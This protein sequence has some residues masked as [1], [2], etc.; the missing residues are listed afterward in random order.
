MHSYSKR[1]SLHQIE[2]NRKG[3]CH[4]SSASSIIPALAALHHLLSNFRD[5]DLLGGLSKHLHEFP[6]DILK[7]HRLLIA[8]MVSRNDTDDEVYS[9]TSYSDISPG[10]RIIAK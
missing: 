10:P 4:S 7:F 5:T 6:T 2:A 3:V 1:N 8:F 9:V